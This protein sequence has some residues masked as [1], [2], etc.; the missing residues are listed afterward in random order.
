MP[1]QLL[2]QNS[3]IIIF[4]FKELQCNR[5]HSANGLFTSTWKEAKLLFVVF[6]GG[7]GLNVSRCKNNTYKGNVAWTRLST[8]WLCLECWEEAKLW[9]PPPSSRMIAS[10]CPALWRVCWLVVWFLVFQKTY[11]QS[12]LNLNSSKTT[13]RNCTYLLGLLAMIKC[14]ICSYQCD[15][16][17]AFNWRRYS[18]DIFDGSQACNNTPIL[19]I[20]PP[21]AAH[22]GGG[23]TPWVIL[24]IVL[25]YSCPGLTDLLHKF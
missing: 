1:K 8:D 4:T 24:R 13:R 16:W 14:S 20:C 23:L 22:Y 11:P 3:N 6:F 10:D 15:N 19:W 7:Y 9:D 2:A 5:T 21:R 18:H 25:T 12:I 17:Y